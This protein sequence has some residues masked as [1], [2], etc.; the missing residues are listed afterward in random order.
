MVTF[1]S[2]RQVA[3]LVGVPT[4]RIRRLYESGILADPQRVG[5]TRLIPSDHV[6]SIR[7][8]LREHGWLPHAEEAAQ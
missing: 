1:L 5:L 7:E 4:W 6:P 2:T 8:T 3:E